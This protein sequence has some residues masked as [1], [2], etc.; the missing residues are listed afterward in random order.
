MLDV[1]SDNTDRTLKALSEESPVLLVFLRHGGCPFC[2]ETLS[3]L[4]RL[5]GK[6]EGAGVRIALV[7]M[8]SDE[9]ASKLFARYGLQDLARF[10]DPGQKLYADFELARGGISAVMGPRVWWSG[11][12]STLSGNLPGIPEGDVRQLGGTFLVHH[13][14]IVKAFRATSSAD[15]PDYQAMACSRESGA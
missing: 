7:H 8:L 2:R 11:L 10:S 6:I 14:E 13:G 15:R 3:E 1:R 4:A 12:K 9:S 5:R